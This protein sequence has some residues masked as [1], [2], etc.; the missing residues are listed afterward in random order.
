M[1]AYITRIAY[2]LPE[3]VEE[4]EKG[5]LLKKTGIERRHVCSDDMTAS[6]MAV[7]A[8]EKVFASDFAKEK[9]DFV[10]Y[11][12]QSPDY[13]LPST[14]CILQDRLGLPKYCG[15]LDFDLGCSG[16]VYGLGL[17]KGLVETGQAKNVLLLTSETYTKYIHPEDH[18]VRPLFGDAATATVISACQEEVPGITGMVYGTDGSGA[19]KLIVPVGG[20]RQ[21][22]Q[23]TP[24]TI[25]EDKYG[26]VRT[27]QNLYM[28]GGAIMNF[29]LEVVP[30][31]VDVILAQTSLKKEEIDY[32][33]FH[34]ANRFIL[35][36]LQQICELSEL[37]YWNDVNEYGNTVSSSIPVALADIMKELKEH[38]KK[39]VLKHVMLVGFGVGLSWGGCVVDLRKSVVCE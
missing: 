7:H 35:K 20:M 9:T 8:A 18:A 30:K 24:V 13:P 3:N 21:R 28:D 14:A 15:A 22:Y 5:R 4:N 17:A 39:K 10:L 1:K 6:D 34:Q 23:D 31:T 32:Y 16:Y 26:N 11:C 38:G 27:N 2:Y 25:T 12:T 37:H 29:A 36:C 19:D 33:V